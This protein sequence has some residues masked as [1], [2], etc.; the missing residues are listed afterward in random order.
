MIFIDTSN[1]CGIFRKIPPE[2]IFESK[3][4]GLNEYDFL[5]QIF[6]LQ[7]CFQSINNINMCFPGKSKP[8][9]SLNNKLAG[10]NFNE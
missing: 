7:P 4:M 3:S 1:I 5:K 9:F 6:S 8:I 10:R 2:N